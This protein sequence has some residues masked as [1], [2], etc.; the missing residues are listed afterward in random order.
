[1]TIPVPGV[2]QRSFERML[3]GLSAIVLIHTIITYGFLIRMPAVPVVAW[4]QRAMVAGYAVWTV[5]RLIDSGWRSRAR[6]F[7][8]VAALIAALLP[9]PAGAGLASFRIVEFYLAPPAGKLASRLL[10]GNIRLN[11]ARVLLLSFL[12]VLLIG[13]VLLM[14]PAAAVDG[15]GTPLIDALFTATSAT[16]VTGLIV[17]DTGVY[18]SRFGQLVILM[19]IQTGGLGIM[20]FSTV[21]AM[22]LGKRIGLKQQEQ[23]RG[24]MDTRSPAEL[25]GLVIRIVQITV[26]LELAGAAI[27]FFRFIGNES[28]GNALYHA[29]FHAV[30]AFCN[31]GFSLYTDS[32]M[33]FDGDLAVNLVIMLLIVTGGLGFIVLADLMKQSSHGNP[34]TIR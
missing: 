12:V 34:F 16:C 33:G 23:M 27:L 6:W 19:L 17:R 14:L 26:L 1:M 29:V 25:Y 8:C 3:G 9:L 21:F 15:Q 18:F 30:S 32:L 2:M 7:D 31:A 5:F 11:P 13:T 24:M 10:I 28:P 20:T 4:I 22:I